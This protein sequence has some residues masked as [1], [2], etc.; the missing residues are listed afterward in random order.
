ME[1]QPKIKYPIE[2]LYCFILNNL[3]SL[4]DLIKVKYI[5]FF[6]I[7]IIYFFINLKL[8]RKKYSKI[9]VF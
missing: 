9:S 1:P 6:I 8:K 7:I 4:D 3:S 5:R 2:D